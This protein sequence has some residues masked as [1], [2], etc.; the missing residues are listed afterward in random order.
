ML[1]NEGHVSENE[2]NNSS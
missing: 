2:I 1:H